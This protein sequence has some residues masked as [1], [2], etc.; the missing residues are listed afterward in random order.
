MCHRV[1]FVC[2]VVCAAW[3]MLSAVGVHT[4][5]GRLVS[6]ELGQVSAAWVNAGDL[7]H[8]IATV[9]YVNLDSGHRALTQG[10]VT[11]VKREVT[12]VANL[13]RVTQ[14]SLAAPPRVSRRASQ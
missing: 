9:T 6:C 2:L 4:T 7:G 14:I 12:Y 11:W 3:R 5:L 13:P 8:T 1:S 10:D